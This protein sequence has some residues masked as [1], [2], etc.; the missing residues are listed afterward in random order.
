MTHVQVRDIHLSYPLMRNPG[1]LRKS[2]VRLAS[3]GRL[4]NDAGADYVSIHAL[5]G[6]SFSFKD[7]DR[8]GLIRPNGAGK[9]T[10]LKV[11]AGIYKP[12]SGSLDIDGSIETLLDLGFGID[13]EETAIENIHFVLRILGTPKREIAAIEQEITDFTELG[14]FMDLPVRTYSKGMLTRLS[15]ALATTSKPDIL[16]MDEVVGAGDAKF[17][18]KAKRRLQ[19]LAEQTKI[20]FLASHSNEL[21]QEWCNKAIWIEDGIAKKQGSMQEV[22]DAYMENQAAG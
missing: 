20:L 8:V 21:I 2:V 15:F 18:Q 5:K 19:S 6:I 9:S 1:S 7:G 10:L 17:Y 4:Q 12:N 22:L 11:L 3:F 14:E 13:L 16:L